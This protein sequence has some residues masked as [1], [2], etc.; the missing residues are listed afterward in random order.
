MDSLSSALRACATARTRASAM[1]PTAQVARCS[2]ALGLGLVK[3]ARL[4]DGAHTRVGHG[5]HRADGA[6]Q[7]RLVV[8]ELEVA[9]VAH[10]HLPRGAARE[11]VEAPMG[12]S[13]AI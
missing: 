3:G 1:G 8:Q 5:P 2:A 11:L 9:R 6:L 13:H 12:H 4:R 7:R 10:Q